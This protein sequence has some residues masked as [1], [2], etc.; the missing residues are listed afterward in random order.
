MS[1]GATQPGSQGA[2]QPGSQGAE[3]RSQGAAQPHG[4]GIQAR[5]QAAQATLQAEPARPGAMLPERDEFDDVA[6]LAPLFPVVGPLDLPADP[7]PGAP[8][9]EP[10]A[11]LA[12]AENEGLAVPVDQETPQGAPAPGVPAQGPSGERAAGG[13]ARGPETAGDDVTS[14][15]APSTGTPTAN[16][17]T[18]PAPD[19]EPGT[20][21][22]ETADA[23]AGRG[24]F[25]RPEDEALP[26]T[27]GMRGFLSR[28]GFSVEPSAEEK[29]ERQWRR[30]I[31]QRL[32]APRTVSVVNGKGGANKTPTAVLLA[33]VFGRNSGD[34]VLAWDNNGTRGTLGW[35]TVQASH[36]AH[37]MDLLHAAPDL[38][39]T[40]AGDPAINAY[41]HY[42]PE[43]RYSVLRT[44]P[45]LLASEQN[46][47][48]A[49]FDIVHAAASKFFQ[50]SIVDSGNDESA[51]RWLRMIDHTDQLVVASTTVE[52]HAEAAALLLEALANRG[53]RYAEL[54]RNAVV[55]VSQHQQN[56]NK[57]QL[58]RIASGFRRLARAVVT[59]PF[60]PALVKGRI[61]YQALR[62]ATRRAWLEAAAAVA[63]GIS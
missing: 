3:P 5:G 19:Q 43:D 60:D 33:A 26:P 31:G 15:D 47:T 48:A 62:P 51:E 35:R 20:T 37:V 7:L 30:A 10:D 44:D 41:V 50:L 9:V 29:E 6:E 12:S 18:E 14:T 1:E 4:Q 42:Q 53:G 46:L 36:N 13:Q 17:P 52:E 27:R 55:I 39:G 16:I 11:A 61:R 28:I 8:V 54:A 21:G 59:V 63:D 25:L 22:A 56:G 38:M 57:D 23:A 34:P 2:T 45:T 24:T 32:S 49:D 40:T 58:A